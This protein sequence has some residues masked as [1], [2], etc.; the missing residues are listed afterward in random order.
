MQSQH[1]IGVAL[2]IGILLGVAIVLFYIA[3]SGNKISVLYQQDKEKPALSDKNNS[4]NS[5]N[6]NEKYTYK[7]NKLKPYTND[8]NTNQYLSSSNDYP[9]YYP[10]Q[11]YKEREVIIDL[12]TADTIA[13]QML[14]GI[15]PSYSKRIYKYGQKL[16]GYVD[17][18]Q[19][20]EVY[21]MTDSLYNA[22]EKHIVIETKQVRK[23]NINTDNIKDLISHPYID[24]YLAK[25]II[26]MRQKYGDYKNIEDIKKVHLMD[27]TTFSKL[28]PYLDI[29]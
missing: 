25:E 20:K 14:R 4:E 13:L 8:R 5:T 23:I 10:K 7:T 21:G 24:Y 27:E 29:K 26:L 6:R 16:G 2:I 17:K 12:N 18:N 15:G 28:T 9:T 11:E 3:F 1:K 22:I 19:L